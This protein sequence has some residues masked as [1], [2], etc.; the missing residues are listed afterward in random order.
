MTG[1]GISAAASVEF[2]FGYAGDVA[3]REYPDRSHL[4]MDVGDRHPGDVDVIRP[5]C[6]RLRTR[7]RQ[8]KGNTA[9]PFATHR[10]PLLQNAVLVVTM[11]RIKSGALQ[12]NVFSRTLRSGCRCERSEEHT[13]E[14][15]SHV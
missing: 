8:P 9:K 7:D 6:A 4:V 10:K 1:I 15:Q 2:F 14:L 12:R 3:V 5:S 13:S 11:H